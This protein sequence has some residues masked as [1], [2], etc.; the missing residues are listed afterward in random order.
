M[1]LGACNRFVALL[2][3]QRRKRI[4]SRDQQYRIQQY[5]KG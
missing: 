3:A 1:T 2:S 4:L 5:L